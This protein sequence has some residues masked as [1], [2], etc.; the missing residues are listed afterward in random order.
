MNSGTI[1]TD[2]SSEKR[3]GNI[4]VGMPERKVWDL[5]ERVRIAGKS[6]HGILEVEA[7][8]VLNDLAAGRN[9]DGDEDVDEWSAIVKT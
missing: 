7:A 1:N 9:F 8:R 5:L 2:A 4:A 6:C 3:I